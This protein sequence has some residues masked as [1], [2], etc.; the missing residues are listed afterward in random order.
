MGAAQAWTLTTPRGDLVLQPG[1]RVARWNGVQIH[2]GFAPRVEAGRLW[3]HG[4]DLEKNV[5]PLLREPPSLRATRRIILLDPG[6]GGADAGTRSVADGRLEKDLTLDLALRLGRLLAER[7]WT[8]YLTRTND[9]TV[10]L[11]ERVAAANALQADFFLSLHFNSAAPDGSQCGLETYCLTP[12]GM[13]SHVTRGY[14]DDPG[15][16]FPNS[17][18][19][20]AN[21][22]YALRL[23]RAAL[24]TGGYVDRGVRRARFMSVLRGQGRPAVLLEAGYLS[25]PQEARRIGDPAFRQRLAEALAAALDQ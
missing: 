24:E 2:L 15:Q 4:L 1:S 12:A 17:V 20:P 6:H 21:L 13:P 22:A 5:L 14:G 11:A 7:G 18:H 9:R 23:H 3:M 19:D 25:H 16:S 10:S 8:V